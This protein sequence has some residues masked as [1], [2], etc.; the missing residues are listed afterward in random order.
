MTS[1]TNRAVTMRMCGL[2]MAL[3]AAACGG[4]SS[5]SAP[6]ASAAATSITGVSV[7]SSATGVWLGQTHQ[8]TATTTLSN[9]ASQ[10]SP[11]GTWGSDAPAVAT[12]NSSGLVTTLSPGDVT[13]YFDATGGGRATKRLSIYADFEGTWTG[14]YQITSCGQT[15]GFSTLGFCGIWTTGS[16]L[17]FR[18]VITTTGSGVVS[19][20]WVLGSVNYGPTSGTAGAFYSSVTL[21]AF[22]QDSSLPSTSMWS[23]TQSLPSRIAGTHQLTIT[24]N[25]YSGSGVVSGP[26]ISFTKS[27]ASLAAT[28]TSLFTQPRQL[29]ELASAFG[30][31]RR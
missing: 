26:I 15:G 31:L 14:N 22:H 30:L 10:S 18:L 28:P 20:S 13:V 29:D 21:S 16:V 11:A 19:A 6:S 9:G 3:A 25:S 4:S 5:P 24:S 2:A 8:M 1:N 7:T 27:L 17:P 23:L 12:V